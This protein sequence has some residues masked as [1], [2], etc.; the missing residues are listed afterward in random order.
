M[1]E[2][3]LGKE[4]R[5]LF[6]LIADVPSLIVQL[7]RDE[8]ESL[9]QE[10]TAKV[11]GVAI[12]AALFAVAGVFAFLML[13]VLIIAGIFGIAATGLPYWASALIVAGALLV[14]AVII[15]LIGKAQFGK[16]DPGKTVES[17]KKDVDAFK[18]ID[19]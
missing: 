18:G 12:G 3:N 5:G 2:Q 9:K 13:I 7:F 10:I 14:I 17:V 6:R 16:G 15:A 11:K 8:L 1:S 19:R 4:K